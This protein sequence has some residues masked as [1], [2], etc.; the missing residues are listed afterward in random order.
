MHPN[1]TQFITKQMIVS[2]TY[3]ERKDAEKVMKKMLLVIH[4]R[5]LTIIDKVSKCPR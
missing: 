4:Q 3:T 1:S 2:A 5:N